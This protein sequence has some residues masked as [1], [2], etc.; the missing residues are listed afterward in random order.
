MIEVKIT[1]NMHKQSDSMKS[2]IFACYANMVKFWNIEYA[3]DISSGNTGK[4]YMFLPN[5]CNLLFIL[6]FTMFTVIQVT[7]VMY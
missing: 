3:V 2:D 6:E 4:V 5:S 7:M 1:C